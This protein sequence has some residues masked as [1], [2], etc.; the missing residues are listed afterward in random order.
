M[1]LVGILAALCGLI[2]FAYRGLERIVAGAGGGADRRRLRG[3]ALAGALDA[4]FHGRRVALRSA[5]FSDLSS[6]RAV[7]KTHGRQRFRHRDR[8]LHGRETRTAPRRA[9]RRSRRRLRNLRRRQPF[10][11]IFRVGADGAEAVPQGG[12]AAPAGARRH[13]AR[14]LDIHHVGAARN[15]GDSKRDS[16]AV[17]WNDAFRRSRA[18]R[19]RLR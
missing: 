19:R 6:R 11:R 1:G 3:R 14:H 17:F 9:L 10:R 16:H 7:W 15:A 12:R 4:D 2:W 13:R 5:I 18:W 8:E